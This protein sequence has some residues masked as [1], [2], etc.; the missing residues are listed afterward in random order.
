[1]PVDV[2]PYQD[3]VAV[4]WGG[5][6]SLLI[7]KESHAEFAPSG[8]FASAILTASIVS[9][10]A[11]GEIRFGAPA[12]N[13][14]NG[15]LNG[16]EVGKHTATKTRGPGSSALEIDLRKVREA[17][18]LGPLQD[19]AGEVPAWIEVQ[20]GGYITHTDPPGG[21]DVALAYN[22]HG[23]PRAFS[24][25]VERGSGY[26]DYSVFYGVGNVSERGGGTFPNRQTNSQFELGDLVATIFV[27]LDRLGFG[28]E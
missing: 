16:V 12:A 1:M 25:E 5:L 26:H 8:S 10:F 22:A 6:P 20:I 23:G 7:V 21:V 11:D 3:I 28:N 24:I 13:G 2:G 15:F 4:S 27:R 14:V 18:A 17:F 19:G 9:T